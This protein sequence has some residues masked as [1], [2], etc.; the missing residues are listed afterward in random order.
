[1]AFLLGQCAISLLHTDQKRNGKRL[2]ITAKDPSQRSKLAMNTEVD[3]YEIPTCSPDTN[4]IESIFYLLR[5]D[6]KDEAAHHSIAS[7][8]L[9]QFCDRF[10]R[11]L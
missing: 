7:E 2:F 9:E 6:L 8:T 11:S 1:M 10:L 3:L 5:S 4:V